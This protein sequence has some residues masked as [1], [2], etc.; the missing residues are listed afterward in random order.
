MQE[1]TVRL[2][3]VLNLPL[4][5]LI[6]LDF[7]VSRSNIIFFSLPALLGCISN[8]AI[9]GLLGSLLRTLACGKRG[10]SLR[11]VLSLGRGTAAL[12][13]S[14]G[15]DA[16]LGGEATAGAARARAIQ[17]A[18]LLLREALGAGAGMLGAVAD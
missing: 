8:L 6:V 10:R 12:S 3:G 9:I 17:I 11:R 14:G 13:R 18:S 1:L 4:A 15:L 16:L 7:P 2:F 5:L